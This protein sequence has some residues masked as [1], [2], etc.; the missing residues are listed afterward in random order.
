MSKRRKLEV[1]SSEEEECRKFFDEKSET[2]SLVMVP[3]SNDYVGCLWP[4]EGINE[5]FDFSSEIG[6]SSSRNNVSSTQ[7]DKKMVEQNNYNIGRQ[8]GESIKDILG[9]FVGCLTR[10]QR[11]IVH[12]V[13]VT[14]SPINYRKTIETIRKKAERR[15]FTLVGFH[16]NGCDCPDEHIHVVHDCPWNSATC[17]CFGLDVRPRRK[18][19]AT[20]EPSTTSYVASLIKYFDEKP[21]T[22]VFIK[23]GEFKRITFNRNKGIQIDGYSEC[24]IYRTLQE[25]GNSSENSLSPNGKELS[26]HWENIEQSQTL[27]RETRLSIKSI[28]AELSKFILNNITYPI[29]NIHQSTIWRNSKHQFVLPSDKNLIRAVSHVKNILTKFQF[30][31]FEK[32]YDQANIIYFAALDRPFNDFYYSIEE[33]IEIALKLLK[34][35][36]EKD[37]METGFEVEE[38]IFEF[39]NNLYNVCEKK[40]PKKNSIYVVSYEPSAGKNFFFD[41]IITFYLNTGH[42]AN[43]NKYSNFPLQDAVNRRILMWNEPNFCD[44]SEDTIKMLLGGD[45]MSVNV[46]Y[47]PYA[48]IYKTP[49]IILSNNHVLKNKAY[50]DRLFMYEWRRA[51]FLKEYDK[52][53]HP[54]FYPQLL[55]KYN[56]VKNGK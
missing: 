14:G 10:L 34:F 38:L 17:K 22:I 35:Q 32:I 7:T 16:P 19:H 51:E 45:T 56:V 42:I 23:I 3:E 33:S 29:D 4:E 18:P 9:F 15:I 37:S 46:K 24:A 44:S 31:D 21:R 49:I 54:L 47:N 12:D 13:I 27:S 36:F 40:I 1:S 20:N 50:E 6:G 55:K 28:P 11:R 48:T 39:L 41:P 25:S 53:I 5:L 52:K 8:C 30:E 43:F 2:R 26:R